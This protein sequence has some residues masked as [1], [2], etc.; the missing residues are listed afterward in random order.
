[1]NL[2]KGPF[3]VLACSGLLIAC[4]PGDEPAAST[5]GGGI[6]T[7]TGTPDSDSD[8]DDSD[9]T[10]SDAETGMDSNA[11][12]SGDG[13][14]DATDSQDT[15]DSQDSTD[16]DDSM[17]G[18]STGTKFDLAGVPDGT[19]GGGGCAVP[20]H[21]PCDDNGNDDIWNALGINCPG[22]PE[23]TTEYTGDPSAVYVHTGQLGT[24]DPPTYPVLE[25]EQ[26]LILSSGIAQELTVGGLYASTSHVGQDPLGLPAP[27]MTNPV[28]PG[29]VITCIDDENL[30]GT[31]DCSNTINDQWEQGSGA[32]DYAELRISGEVPAGASGFSYQL[33]FFS[34]EYPNFY[35]SSFNDMYIAWLESE[36][37]TGNVSFD[38]MGKPISLNAG[39]LDYKDA[40]N[41]NDCPDPC[42][43]PELQ[44]TAMEGHAGTRWL[45]TTAGVVPGEDFELVLAIFDLTDGILD[46][47]VILDNFGWNCE[48]GPPVTIPG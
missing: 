11:T 34:T 27:M 14:G 3:I 10:D 31:G 5:S 35:Q 17:S 36:I 41:P 1:M 4:Q 15:T 13:D 42:T 38:E 16:S 43:A 22:E 24:Y 47:V 33:A 45:T 6:P 37:W 12:N 26:M 40:P 25:G 20:P 32:N 29:Q 9:S 19:G 2:S 18:S 23:L 28:D 48:G 30:I 8:S 39:F 21:N 44:G 7:T 46:S